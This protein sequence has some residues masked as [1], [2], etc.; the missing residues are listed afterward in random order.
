MLS[1]WILADLIIISKRISMK[2]LLHWSIYISKFIGRKN[3]IISFFGS[4]AIDYIEFHTHKG[5]DL[6]R[7]SIWHQTTLVCSNHVNDV[8]Q[9]EDIVSCFSSWGQCILLALFINLI[10]TVLL[11]KFVPVALLD[12]KLWMAV[13]ISWRN[14]KCKYSP[15]LLKV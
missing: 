12:L 7:S 1:V 2:R 13:P 11:L 10:F 8:Q 14:D 4:I 9:L 5:E 15:L 3:N 6:D